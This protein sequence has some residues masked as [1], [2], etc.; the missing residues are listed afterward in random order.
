MRM[1][2]EGEEVVQR[3][4]RVTQDGCWAVVGEAEGE[5]LEILMVRT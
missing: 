1:V 2:A 3:E 5:V 4:M